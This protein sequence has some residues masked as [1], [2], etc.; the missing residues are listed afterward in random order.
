MDRY[1]GL[2]EY[3]RAKTRIFRHAGQCIVNRD[4]P[5]SRA[6]LHSRASPVSF[7]LGPPENHLDFGLLTKDGRRMLVKGKRVL[8]DADR[9]TLPGDHNIAN[10]L[11]AMALVDASGVA[12]TPGVVN[13]AAGYGGLPHRCEIVSRADGVQWINDS[14]GTNAGATIAAIKG[15]SLPLILIAG[16]QGKG[17]DFGPLAEVIAQQVNHTILFGEDA[18]AIASRLDESVQHTRA[19]S[20]EEAVSIAKRRA[21]PGWGVLFSPACASFDL[22]D[23]YAHRGNVFRNLVLEGVH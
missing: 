9:L 13:A 11:A 8:V 14:K 2:A 16:G 3:A 7:G 23:N 17:A 21:R 5:L 20:L 10:I 12:L 19:A 4:D 18:Q 1:D 22:F 15:F 6:C